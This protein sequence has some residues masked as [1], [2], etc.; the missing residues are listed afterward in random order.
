[1]SETDESC[2]FCNIASAHAPYPPSD[3]PSPSPSV[4]SP[5]LTSPASFVVLSTPTL[6]SF[7]DIMPLSFGHLLVCPRPHRPKLSDVSPGEARELG[8][9]VRILSKALIRATGVEDWN[10]VQNNGAAAAQVVPHTH[11]H[12][13]PRPDIRARGKISESFTMFGKGRREELDDDEAEKLAHSIR[14]EVA[15]VLGEEEETAEGLGHHGE[16][17]TDSQAKL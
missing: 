3:P 9:A 16:P 1:M 14:V 4:L 8:A 6:I 7:L 13:I 2:P 5:S 17:R 15:R 11:Y 12:L 10:V